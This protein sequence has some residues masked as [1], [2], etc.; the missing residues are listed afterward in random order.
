MTHKPRDTDDVYESFENNL[1]GKITKLTNFTRR[2]FNYIFTR[3]FAREV[4]D[5]EV[6]ALAT[7]LSGQI[8]YAGGPITQDDLDELGVDTVAPSEVNEYMDDQ[9]LDELVKIVGIDRFE[10]VRAAG[11]IEIETQANNTIIP[12]GTVVTTD[13][14]ADGNT[15]RYETVEQVET[16]DGVTIVQ[17]VNIQSIGSGEEYNV[18]AQ[19][20]TRFESPP[21]GVTGVRNPDPV[22]G[23]EDRESN[24]ELRTRAKNAT[25][26]SS[27][28]GTTS[29]IRGY[30]RKEVE[31]VGDG[32]IFIDEFTDRTPPVVD[33]VVDGGTD[34]ANL[35]AIDFSRPTGIRHTLVRPENIEVG[36]DV[37][38]VGSGVDL[39]NITETVETYLLDKGVSETLYEDQIIQ[40]ILNS[41][42]N[43]ENI[44]SLGGYIERVSNEE[45]TYDNTKTDY[46]LDYTF[47]DR[48]GTFQ[49]SDRSGEIYTKGVDYT[50]E[51]KS[52]DGYKDTIVWDTSSVTPDDGERFSV[53]Y[54]VTV[55]KDTATDKFTYD[56]TQQSYS[57]SYTISSG[58]SATVVTED[59][60]E[61]DQGT[62][63][64]LTDTNGDSLLD[65]VE[66]NTS[67]TVPNDKQEFT[68]TYDLS[69]D[70]KTSEDNFYQSDEKRHEQF[71]WTQ[72]FVEDED[73]E[74]TQDVYQLEY[75]PFK[76][77]V[78]Q[79]TDDDGIT[80][81][82]GTDY[83]L[84]DDTGNGFKQSIDWSIGGDTPTD[85]IV[86][87]VEY[88]QKLY[89]T[90]NDIINTKNG[91]IV[92]QD[93]NVYTEN[94]DFTI[95][96]Y[97]SGRTGLD[98]IVWQSNPSSLTDTDNF[99]LS[100]KTEGG[101]LVGDRQKITAGNITANTI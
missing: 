1:R 72:N 41:T 94:T 84:I 14:D 28:G 56:D 64:T 31:G 97:R 25:Q 5:V 16:A 61:F 32:D 87:T 55:N 10:G 7:E 21:L 33:V 43:V 92:D 36:A 60:T 100:Y 52:G 71:S 8:D 48:N 17:N 39:T 76:S 3:A 54:D 95:E 42:L 20:I 59:G 34:Q 70:S 82:E 18:P 96:S 57:I 80:Y 77:S 9:S 73:Y 86:F 74:N 13:A 37:V 62:D 91:E 44:D 58:G 66:W 88:T 2:S 22:T 89:Q 78:Q 24:E 46:R 98:S 15:L 38:V 63:F 23:G 27:D 75:V 101:V 35:E 51:D 85:N 4:H 79:I 68:V 93:G 50:V 29:G 11:T 99:Y 65:T 12:E 49:L 81:D 67:N 40:E 30:I 26:T 19:T 90:E 83:A 45:F 53:D 69:P 6:R 47:E